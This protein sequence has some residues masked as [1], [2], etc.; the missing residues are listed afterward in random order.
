MADEPVYHVTFSKNLP[1]IRQRGL[2]PIQPSLYR[3]ATPEGLERYQSEPSVF[4]FTN[5][6]EALD[7]AG[8][9]SWEFRDEAPENLD[10]SIIKLR[11]GKQWG[12]DPAAGSLGLGRSSKRSLSHIS[13]EDIL[14]VMTYPPPV[15]KDQEFIASLGDDEEQRE[16]NKN[17]ANWKRFYSERLKALDFEF[18]EEKGVWDPVMSGTQISEDESIR[19]ILKKHNELK[20]KFMEQGLSKE[21]ADKKAYNI[22]VP[23]DEPRPTETADEPRPTEIEDTQRNLLEQAWS[24]LEKKPWTKW[25]V[26]DWVEKVKG[27]GSAKGPAQQP[28]VNNALSIVKK[29]LDTLT[30][31]GLARAAL[32]LGGG[33][34]GLLI[35]IAHQAYNDL[36][37]VEKEAF[38]RFWEEASI[39]PLIE[40]YKS[41]KSG[42]NYLGEGINAFRKLMRD[43]PPSTEGG[44]GTLPEAAPS[45]NRLLVMGCS[46]KKSPAECAIEARKMY[47][48][49]LWEIFNKSLGGE[50]NVM[51]GLKDRGIDVGIFSAEHGFMHLN[52]KIPPYDKKL[53]TEAATALAGDEAKVQKVKDALAR[54]DPS[55][56]TLAMG[57]NYRDVF[58]EMA[59]KKFNYFGGGI[60]QQRGELK[61]FFER[62]GTEA[63]IETVKEGTP[64][65]KKWFG[66]GAVRD[67]QDNPRKLFHLT[68]SDFDVFEIGEE[69]LGFHIGSAH[70]AENR[71]ELKRREAE[72]S[73]ELLGPPR[74]IPLYT[75][76]KNPL[77]MPE[78]RG[79]KWN[80]LDFILDIQ[81]SLD[82]RDDT[83]IFEREHLKSQYH[84]QVLKD[85][86]LTKE[87]EAMFRGEK[88]FLQKGH[89]VPVKFKGREIDLYEMEDQEQSDFVR[90]WLKSKGFDSIVYENMWEGGGDS[91]LLF[92]PT[93]VKSIFNLRPGQ[94]E[95][96]FKSGGIVTLPEF[97]EGGWAGDPMDPLVGLEAEMPDILGPLKYSPEMLAQMDK[98]RADFDR[99]V[100]EGR[101]REA[102]FAQPTLFENLGMNMLGAGV[103]VFHGGPSR[104]L[105]EK[106]FPKGRPRLDRVGTGEGAQ[107]Y[108]HGFYS[109]ESKG[110]AESYYEA[111]S[112]KKFDALSKEEQALVPDWVSNR[113]LQG[114]PESGV[115]SAIIEFTNRMQDDL[116]QL[117]DPNVR[118]PWL[119]EER[120]A[121]HKKRIKALEKL[122]T[123]K[124]FGATETGSLKKLDI[125]DE[126]IAKFLDWDA[127]LSE[128]P[129]SVRAALKGVEYL[130]GAKHSFEGESLLDEIQYI[131]DAVKSDPRGEF[132]HGAL[133]SVLG[134]RGTSEYLEKL[135]IPGLKYYDQMS[136]GGKEGTRNYVVWD[137]DVLDRTKVYAQ[138]GFVEKPVFRG[139]G[140]FMKNPVQSLVMGA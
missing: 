133:E 111:L 117:K 108:G 33:P 59:G 27:A 91:Y 10:Y 48:G 140:H 23:P 1:E 94:T 64:E 38:A 4:A 17:Y 5:P 130:H 7:W 85:L 62:T 13:P 46:A 96:E 54:Y 120:I 35:D 135:G 24:V 89:R 25:E 37:P 112:K 58:E 86:K 42:L 125:P 109:A 26:D 132:L 12:K 115:N 53:T 20:N 56:I 76:I 118:Q 105:A 3:R 87:E 32:K 77:R 40:A 28:A 83:S 65:L 123:S 90:T 88:T 99:L 121:G 75:N 71:M 18:E 15:M 55:S 50:E 34:A 129:E 21:E 82:Y 106:G 61:K 101:I 102:A 60:G 97:A 63:P 128:Q 81:H 41:D 70:T 127:P 124:D 138:G 2:S 103:T 47:K 69:D 114:D 92:E 80:T 122:E 45:P 8:H 119:I 107:A 116:A 134:E 110:V 78:V 72:K 14:D 73:G 9:M 43:D 68:F 19:R 84:P 44:I 95:P 51:Q 104:W 36:T 98:E 52:E 67:P 137:Q 30:K 131:R 29:T 16:L 6:E 39:K 93:Q 31:G 139:V 126:D 57:K 100:K 74:T 113:I 136:R 66:K 11:G 22:L 49:S 79:G